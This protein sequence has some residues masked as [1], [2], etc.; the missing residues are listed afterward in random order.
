[1]KWKCLVLIVFAMISCYTIADESRSYAMM[2]KSSFSGFQCATLAAQVSDQ[3]EAERLFQLGYERGYQFIEALRAGKIEEDDL[4]SSAPTV[5]LM[6]LDGPSTDFMLGRIYEW[7]QKTV[8]DE[9]YGVP[10]ESGHREL[11]VKNE[12]SKRNCAALGR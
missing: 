3:E 11:Y 1:M 10:E 9:V 7:A 2:A 4:R 5:M 6:L 8:L 12:F